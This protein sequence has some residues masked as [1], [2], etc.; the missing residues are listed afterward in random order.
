MTWAIRQSRTNH[1][2]RKWK[3]AIFLFLKQLHGG[4]GGLRAYMYLVG[5]GHGHM[6]LG[7]SM[8]LD[9]MHGS[10]LVLLRRRSR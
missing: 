1:L 2:I 5:Y 10:Q 8:I 9:H 6:G 7:S 4:I 3:L